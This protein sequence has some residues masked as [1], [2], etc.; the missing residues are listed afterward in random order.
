MKK[1]TDKEIWQ[2]FKHHNE[3]E[4]LEILNANRLA[5]TL[6]HTPEKVGNTAP[7]ILQT[8]LEYAHRTIAEKRFALIRGFYLKFIVQG[9]SLAASIIFG[10]YLGLN[11]VNFHE[12]QIYLETQTN[13]DILSEDIFFTEEFL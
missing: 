10:F 8:S 9:F 2:A 13:L 3:I 1:H 12:Q 6:E 5:I 7:D 11:Q 4:T